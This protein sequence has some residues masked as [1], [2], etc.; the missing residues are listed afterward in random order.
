MSAQAALDRLLAGE[1]VAER[2]LGSTLLRRMAP[3]LDG[4]V[5]ERIRSRG[6]KLR[7]VNHK[8]LQTWIER[9]YPN[10][11]NPPKPA[12]RAE[13]VLLHGDSKKARVAGSPTVLLRSLGDAVLVAHDGSKIHV[14]TRAEGMGA[15]GLDLAHNRPTTTS[16]IA[17]VENAEPFYDDTL[18]ARLGLE[19]HLLIYTHGNPSRSLLEW[20]AAAGAPEIIHLPDYDTAGL[21]CF[22]RLHTATGGLA[23][24]YVP[25]EFERLARSYGNHRLALNLSKSADRFLAS[26]SHPLVREVVQILLRTGTGL[27]QE[28]LSLL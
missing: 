7:P 21:S 23:T 18:L 2:E 6:N 15:L 28:A 22:L 12:S 17:V 24:L 3:L 19:Q 9:V 4:G 1:D 16:P 13:A 11:I 27:E 5:I 25:N 26:T 14:R 20:I 10:G 8:A